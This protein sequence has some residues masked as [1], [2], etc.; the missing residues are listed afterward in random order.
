M[1]KSIEQLTSELI[2]LSKNER[3]E[4]ARFLLFLDNH[5]PDDTDSDSIWKKEISDR[6]HAVEIGTAIG[7]DYDKALKKIKT[8]FTS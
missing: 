6:V 3:L 8:R 4:I 2:E 5:S 7:I 1:Q